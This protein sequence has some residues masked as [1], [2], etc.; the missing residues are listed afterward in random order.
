[1]GAD[2]TIGRPLDIDSLLSLLSS[3]LANEVPY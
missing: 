2:L 3:L 1:M